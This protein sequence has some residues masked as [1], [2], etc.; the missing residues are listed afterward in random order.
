M[1]VENVFKSKEPWSRA[2][3]GTDTGAHGAHGAAGGE[4][5]RQQGQAVGDPEC[6]V[7]LPRVAESTLSGHGHSKP[8]SLGQTHRPEL[9]QGGWILCCEEA[10]VLVLPRL[11]GS[12]PGGNR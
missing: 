2:G 7:S 11:P 5:E 3:Q 8:P 4:A 6:P 10:P 1:Q 12:E 9:T